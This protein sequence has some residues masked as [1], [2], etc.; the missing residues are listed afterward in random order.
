MTHVTCRL[1]AKKRD[2]LRNPTLGNRVWATFFLILT[3]LHLHYIRPAFLA[4]ARGG[5]VPLVIPHL[6]FSPWVRFWLTGF[7]VKPC[8]LYSQI[9]W[10]R[11]SL[12][13]A[14]NHL[15]R[16]CATHTRSYPYPLGG[17]KTTCNEIALL[18]PYALVNLRQNVC[19]FYCVDLKFAICLK[20]I[21]T[22]LI[23]VWPA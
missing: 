6:A 4:A 15:V 20:E 11:A 12:D 22:R 1:T 13:R 23:S 17:A 14:V 2:Q 9:S 3:I 8:V 7:G 18:S 10:L 5:G 19:Q 16:T 21:Y